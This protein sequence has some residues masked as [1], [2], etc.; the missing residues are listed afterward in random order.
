MN[1]DTGHLVRLT[2]KE[3]EEKLKMLNERRAGYEKL[4]EELNKAAE[5][6]LGKNDEAFVSL[7]SGG[8]LSTWAR[9]KRKARRKNH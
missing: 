4:P 9:N 8:R 6:K 5:M 1:T 7:T 3:E 2:P